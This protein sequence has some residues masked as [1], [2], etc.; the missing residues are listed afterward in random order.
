MADSIDVVYQGSLRCLATR[1]DGTV[2]VI[3]DA[4][5]ALGGL[6]TSFSPT[7]LL[8]ASLGTCVLTTLGIVA[9]R[10]GADLIGTRLKIDYEMVD[11]P[12]RRIAW[13]QL[14]VTL[15]EGASYPPPLLEK[16]RRAVEFCPIKQSLH[17]DVR[18]SVEWK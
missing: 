15:P 17:P 8:A 14:A 4:S 1:G 9:E 10:A 13:L 12:V 2:T 3:S 11:A 5:L 7:D 16:F 18:V 6:G